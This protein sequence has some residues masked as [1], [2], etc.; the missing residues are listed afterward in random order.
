MHVHNN[1]LQVAMNIICTC[2]RTI[3]TVHTLKVHKDYKQ[4]M[5]KMPAQNFYCTKHSI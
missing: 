4:S 3:S 2:L 5:I 1:T